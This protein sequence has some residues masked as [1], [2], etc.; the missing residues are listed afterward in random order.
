MVAGL[1]MPG[2]SGEFGIL[3]DFIELSFCDSCWP[4]FIYGMFKE[5]ICLIFML[6]LGQN[7]KKIKLLSSLFYITWKPMFN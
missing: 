3:I 5:L 4:C 7:I 1:K 2:I 6:T